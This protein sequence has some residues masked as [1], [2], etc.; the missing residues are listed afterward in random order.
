LDPGL[1][2]PPAL[3][4]QIVAHLSA[5]L[6]EEACG[7]VAGAAGK[8][9]LVLPVENSL[10]SP[11]RFRMAPVD[12]FKA[13]EQFEAQGWELVAIYHSHPQGPPHPSPTDLAEFFYPG[14]LVLIGCPLH[15]EELS[16]TGTKLGLSLNHWQ[17]R[18]FQIDQG[19]YN[20]VK[21]GI[22]E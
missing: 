10:H 11:V 4:E 2:V 22:F 3:L 20:E 7:L 18:A 1:R 17:I 15:P 9:E 14:T 8:A 16:P 21:L 5:H 6:P 12:Q 19:R 13:F